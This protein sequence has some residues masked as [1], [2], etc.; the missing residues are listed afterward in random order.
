MLSPLSQIYKL[1]IKARSS[2]YQKGF[3]T[4]YPLG[5]PTISVGNITVGGTGK[6]PL[7]ASIAEIL[8]ESGEKVCVL[9]RGYGR[10]NERERV[11][12]SDGEKI[13][14]GV[15]KSG[16]EPFE[17]ANK[18]RGKAMVIADAN[19]AS[20]GN[21]A[22]EQFGVTAFV[23]DDAFQH[24][25]VERDLDIVA[26]DATN[27]F[28]NEK[29]LPAGILR[30]PLS[31]LSRA[32]AIIITRANLAEREIPNLKTK[33]SEFTNCPIFL[34]ANKISDLINLQ[35]FTKNQR[36]AGGEQRT[37]KKAL[38]FCALGN[39]TNFF[40]QLKQENFNLAS[41]EI[42]AD[43]HFYTRKDVEKLQRKAFKAGAEIFLTTAKDAV[44]LAALKFDLPCF[45]VETE[46]VF[47][48]EKRLREIIS[49]VFKG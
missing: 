6:T 33:I 31:A 46:I 22:R 24:L 3:F 28:G 48:N 17:L 38:A 5:A 23:L 39:P 11:L 35:E 12:V 16:D 20:A 18:L 44:K 19:R 4:S 1:V 36:T 47:D 9:S 32:D 45:V 42:F 29:V 21:W 14:A 25:R 7:V 37:T 15:E 30:E 49:A 27:P 43:H 13:L 8:A 41:T 40:N 10:D 26:I 34:A 2:F